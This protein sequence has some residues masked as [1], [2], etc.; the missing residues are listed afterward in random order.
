[1]I[2]MSVCY[3]YTLR[4][5]MFGF[6]D[7]PHKR[8]IPYLKVPYSIYIQPTCSKFAELDYVIQLRTQTQAWRVCFHRLVPLTKH[9]FVLQY[10]DYGKM[11]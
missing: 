4:V 9:L 1:M 11:I 8:V 6:N 10:G 2:I 3:P 5:D 7:Y